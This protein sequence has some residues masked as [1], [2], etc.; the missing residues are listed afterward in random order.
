[1]PYIKHLLEKYFNLNADHSQDRFKI[2]F[3][4]PNIYN[5]LISSFTSIINN[6]S[7]KRRY[8]GLGMVMVPGYDM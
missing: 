8:P 7:I 1:M 4:D 2:P 6:K 3:S 5:Q